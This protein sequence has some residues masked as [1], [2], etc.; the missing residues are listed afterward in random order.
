MHWFGMILGG[1]VRCAWC[2]FH[3]GGKGGPFGFGD[4]KERERLAMEMKRYHFVVRPNAPVHG[5]SVLVFV[6]DQGVQNLTDDFFYGV[7]DNGGFLDDLGG[8]DSM[9]AR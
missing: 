5:H 1:S 6:F 3:P 7:Q 4:S 8:F 2:G 9:P